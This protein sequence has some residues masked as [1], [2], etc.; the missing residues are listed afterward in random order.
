MVGIAPM[1]TPSKNLD[2]KRISKLGAND[3]MTE[4]KKLQP[5]AKIPIARVPNF[6]TKAPEGMAKI[7]PTKPVT[8]TSDPTSCELTL[9][10]SIINVE[11]EATLNK[12]NATQYEAKIATITITKLFFELFIVNIF[13]KEWVWNF[14]CY[15]SRNDNYW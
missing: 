9:K 1:L 2:A 11:V 12:L 15:E 14:A 10:A 7:K 5:T 3:P 6:V 8:E 13:W 4:P